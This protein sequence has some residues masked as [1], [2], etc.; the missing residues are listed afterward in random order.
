MKETRNAYLQKFGEGISWK[1]SNW[2]TEGKGS[3]TLNL[4]ARR[5]YVV[6]NG[7]GWK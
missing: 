6:R 1:T 5:F 3:L 7:G 4:S 2:K